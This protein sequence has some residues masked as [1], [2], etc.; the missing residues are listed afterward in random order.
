MAIGAL[1]CGI[2]GI[3]LGWFPGINYVALVLAILGIV[4]GA[5]ARKNSP[6]EK[7]GLATAGLVLGIIGTVCAGIGV[8]ACSLCAAGA[9]ALS[10][11]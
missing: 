10:L 3:V 11:F 2:V 1:V 6:A 4:L 7:K 5:I 9:S 8:I